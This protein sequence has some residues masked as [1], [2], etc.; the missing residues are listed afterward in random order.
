MLLKSTVMSMED[1]KTFSR[2]AV[3]DSLHRVLKFYGLESSAD[4]YYNE[5]NDFTPLVG[6]FKR[7]QV[8]TNTFTDGIWR[9]KIFIIP[10]WEES[11]HNSGYSNQRREMTERPVWM[12][13]DEQPF[14]IYPSLSGLKVTVGVVAGFNSSK[15]ADQFRRRINRLQSNQV[16]AMNFSASGHLV[17][18]PAIIDLLTNVHALYKK[19]DPTTPDFPEW[20]QKYRK[21]PFTAASDASGK[22]KLLVVPIVMNELGIYFTEPTVKKSRNAATVGMYE[23]EFGYYFYWKQFDGWELE[24][25]LNVYQDEIDPIWIPRPDEQYTKSFDVRVN[26]EMAFAKALTDTRHLN[27]PYYLRLPNHDPWKMPGLWWVQ[28]VIQARLAVDNVER[29]ELCNIFQIPGWKW[30]DLAKRYILRRRTE[31]FRQFNTPFLVTVWSNDI[32]VY[33]EHLEMDENGG[34]WLLRAPEMRN[35][36]RIVVTVDYAVRDYTGSFWTDLAHNPDDEEILPTLFPGFDWANLDKPWADK[37]V[38]IRK[39]IDKG[40]GIAGPDFNGYMMRLGLHAHVLLEKE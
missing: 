17:V 16:V 35:T 9:N 33:P 31:A 30:S 32:R 1:Y 2:P 13:D 37:E 22:N 3:M 11:Q 24:Y 6:S 15:S 40:R 21:V 27:A 8:R 23:V 38:E 36:Y 18:N 19:N 25:P 14:M 26:P 7:D 29:Q 28:P 34:V 4:I 20:F 39:G 5:D 10:E 12:T